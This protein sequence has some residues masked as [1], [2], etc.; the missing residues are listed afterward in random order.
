MKKIVEI[1]FGI[2]CAAI[3]STA[4]A[5]VFTT[6][7]LPTAGS[8]LTLNIAAGRSN[9]AGT[10]VPY[11]AGTLTMTA[12]TTNYVYLNTASSCV[13]AVKTTTF[14]SSDI[15]IAVVVAGSS[16]ITSVTDERTYA[17]KPSAPGGG[18]FSNGLGT[19]YQD[20]TEIAAPA[21]PSSGND[22]LYLDSATHKLACLTSAGANCMPA[23]SGGGSTTVLYAS[24]VSGA[25]PGVTVSAGSSASGTT[26]SASALNT[27][28][29]A[30]NVDLE[31]DSGF[32]LSTSL[33][34][35]SNTTI[36]CTSP[37]YGFIM[38]T[39]ANAPVFVNANQNA[40]T[41]TSGTGGWVVSNQTD[42]NIKV[43]G[44]MINAN[45]TQAVTGSGNSFGT[46]HTTNPAT[47]VLV[48]AAQF[49]GVNGLRMES[50]EIYDSGEWG[51]L[52]TNDS[53]VFVN[54]NYYHV[55]QPTVANKNTS[56]LEIIG[57]IL[58]AESNGNIV[59][60]G[61]NAVEIA[62]EG[63]QR[64][65]MAECLITN[66]KWGPIQHVHVED[67]TLANANNGVLLLSASELLDD[68][69]IGNLQGNVCD[70]V[71][72]GTEYSSLSTYG[73]GN[74]GR[75][76]IHGVK[77]QTNGTCSVIG[78][79]MAWGL[80][81]VALTIEGVEY[82]NP[83][84]TWPLLETVAGQGVIKTLNL[85]NWVVNTTSSSVAAYL[86]YLGTGTVTNFIT[87]NF[88]WNDSVGT[89]IA[90]GGGAAP[91]TFTCS[92][93]G[94]RGANGG[95]GFGG[96]SGAIN[97]GDCGALTQ[98]GGTSNTNPQGVNFIPSTVNAVGLTATPSN[99][100]GKNEKVEI[101]GSINSFTWPPSAAVP[102]FSPAAGSIVSG[103][104]VNTTCS[105]GS[106]YISTGTTAVAGATGI[107]V[108][109]SQTLYGS[110]QGSGYLTTG[111]AAYTTTSAF[112]IANSAQVSGV[113]SSVSSAALPAF[114]APLT[115]P[116][117]IV[118][119]M[120]SAG[121]LTSY[122]VPTDTAGN[123]YVDCGP[124]ATT[125]S[126]GKIQC[127]YALNTHTTASNVVTL[128]ATGS[129]T[130]LS[131]AAMEITGAN[132]SSPIDG[133]SGVGYSLKASATGGAAGS[134]NIS[135]T[136]LTPAS[137]N[138]MILALF[139]A[140]NAVPT[141]GTSPNLFT[142]GAGAT[143]NARSEY[144]I[145]STAAAITATASDSFSSDSYGAIVVAI[146]H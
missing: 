85:S 130:F 21:N 32:A 4:A 77:A 143:W 100:A 96:F 78:K 15:P 65:G 40:P 126:P 68:V 11:S 1:L 5:Q 12:S 79:T 10:M 58:Y 87:D 91:T 114:S 95:T 105:G 56:F 33:V 86:T 43:I 53:N 18:A 69:D 27:A 57:P 145:Q 13:P 17:I 92:N 120:Y 75:V 49:L 61:D 98:T 51:V 63:C 132:T 131:G 16:T 26:D 48:T 140:Q 73:H 45:S 118:V 29:A 44:C 128:H 72:I 113:S 110:C 7:Y 94:G 109:S 104:T 14:T 46:P 93:Y 135:G 97:A 89:G 6:L 121:G 71:I 101:T 84:V 74:I 125:F 3:C 88:V 20:A 70:N 103:T 138:D 122:T 137:N 139:V 106:P 117:L 81:T 108:S 127:F 22:R 52:V 99:P 25:H 60:S 39:S 23:G 102:T 54:R 8:G 67:T 47:G 107:V 123:T 82:S 37:Q 83:A 38:Q 124:G 90:F 119:H 133:G 142:V 30:G 9:C 116:S 80:N 2:I 115:N 55:P 66:F 141:V 41:T 31:V 144:F 59:T 134:D 62:T 76:R 24:A 28:I 19:G 42:N 129:V 64:I 35:H 136:S 36:H 112:A 146:K 111:S 50:N 34:L